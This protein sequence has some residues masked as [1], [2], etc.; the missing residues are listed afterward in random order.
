M[1]DRP[2][3][4]TAIGD[5]LGGLVP[6]VV[7]TGA[8]RVD[9]A[10]IDRLLPDELAAVSRA[11]AARRSEFATGRTLLRHLTGTDG[12]IPV[13]SDRSPLL[14]PGWLASL[15]H[16]GPVVV[17]LASDD[18]DVAALG[19]DLEPAGPMTDGEVAVVRRDDDPP[20]DGR[21]AMVL[22]EAAY[23]AWSGLGGPLIDFHDVRLEVD[24]DT[25]TAFAPGDTRLHGRW[26]AVAEHWLAAVTVT[27]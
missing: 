8:L 27:R 12:A 5:A 23:K 2:H 4:V 6:P 11:V 18:P 13:S 24:A 14:P 26:T 16:A 10:L 21:A 1:T 20:L 22:K 7:R 17:A 3:D 25:F 9:P 19:V 15:A